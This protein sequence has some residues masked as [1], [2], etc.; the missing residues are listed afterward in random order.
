MTKQ[1]NFSSLYRKYSPIATNVGPTEVL[2]S[3]IHPF[4][5]LKEL[6]NSK[7]FESIHELPYNSA[8][9]I[10]QKLKAKEEEAIRKFEFEVQMLFYKKNLYID[11]VTSQLIQIH[12]EFRFQLNSVNPQDLNS[13]NSSVAFSFGHSIS[14]NILQS[15]FTNHHY[16]LN[17]KNREFLQP[18]YSLQEEILSFKFNKKP[19]PKRFEVL[20]NEYLRGKYI[21]RQTSFE[22]FTSLF[23]GQG[24]IE[25]IN[26]I[27]TKAT[28]YYFITRLINSRLIEYPK[29][30]HWLITAEFFTIKG[31]RLSR[32]D[33]KNHKPP[34]NSKEGHN[35]LLFILELEYSQL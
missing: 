25:K 11:E 4:H 31:K 5:F 33:F 7:D 18:K 2:V 12:N 32:N 21:D 23:D 30:K 19:E 29:N 20:F 34:K 14:N 26:W 22:T 24:V 17:S 6:F 27:N 1:E 8:L 16:S 10:F 3:E 13:L 35:I 28:L 15:I 9:N